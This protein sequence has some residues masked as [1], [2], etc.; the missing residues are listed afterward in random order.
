MRKDKERGAVVVEGLLSLS[1]FMFAIFTILSIVNVC[2]IQ[3][4]MTVA[5]SSAAKEISQYSFFY[6]KFGIDKLDEKF[7]EGTA[8]KRELADNTIEGVSTLM[9]SLTKA[10]NSAQTGDF[11][12]MITEIEGGMD[13][14]DSLVNEYADQI[15]QDPKGFILG[16]GKM[17]GNELKEEGKSILC[18][19][20][21]KAFMKKNLKASP[22]DDADDFLR[23]YKVVDGMDGL[24][25]KYTTFLQNGTSNLIQLVVTYDVKVI[26]L[27]NIDF[28]FT[29]RSC[30][31]ATAW[32]RGIS[33]INPDDSMPTKSPPSTIWDTGPVARGKYIVD[34]EREKY[35]Y[36]ASGNGY[37][38]YDSSTNTF[39][40]IITVDTTTDSATDE[41]QD[42]IKKQLEQALKEM[43]EGADEQTDGIEVTGPDGK[44]ITVPEGEGERNYTVVLVVP[45]N[46]DPA[47][48]AE[49][50]AKFK[51]A[52]PGVTVEVRDGYGSP[53]PAEPPV[54]TP[55]ETDE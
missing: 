22:D 28:D 21:T 25:F 9:D 34:Q 52:H 32:G 47:L 48:V 16:M 5:L 54:E 14:I 2:Y 36:P 11:G 37:D 44:T 15:S 29:F 39:V 46:A 53:T 3:A 33:K 4:K 31:K 13:N 38:A 19:A 8:E 6:Y 45:D 1:I 55:E 42:Y 43:Q 30:V 50:V 17:I 51:E 49:Q 7:S 12:D 27:L 23:R 35:E 18:Q 26:Q 10:S 40:S 41:N 24:D 20:L